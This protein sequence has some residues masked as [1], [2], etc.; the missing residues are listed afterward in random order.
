MNE[1]RL[2]KV[3]DGIRN[4]TKDLCVRTA[5]IET[6]LNNHLKQQESKF[7]KSTILLG[8]AVAVVALIATI[9]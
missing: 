2:W 9:K 3:L 5:I 8:I 6:N 1:D 7:N 4:D